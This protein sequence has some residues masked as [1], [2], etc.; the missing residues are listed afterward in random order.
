M[1][2]RHKRVPAVEKCFKILEALANSHE[3]LGISEISR[4]LGLN[5]STVYNITYTLADLHVLDCLPSGKFALG[6]LFQTLANIAGKRSSIIQMVHPYLETIKEKT[7]LSVF[8]GVRSGVQAVLID[9]VEA[10][11]GIKLSSE[12]GMTMPPLAGA[13]IKAMLSELPE[14][15]IDEIL[16]KAEFR[17]FTDNSIVDKEKF[18]DELLRV[19]KEGIAYDFEEYIQGM[20]GLSVPVRTGSRNVQSAVWVVGIKSQLPK[21]RIEEVASL[22]LSIAREINASIQKA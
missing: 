16:S 15:K 17:R 12:I 10:D 20:I 19:K 2:K 4:K 14:E 5:K 6:T 9:K 22:L 1:E 7:G 8:L 3:P 21:E 11:H 13:G 18:K